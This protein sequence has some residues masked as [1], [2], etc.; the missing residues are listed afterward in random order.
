MTVIYP[1]YPLIALSEHLHEQPRPSSPISM[2]VGEADYAVGEVFPFLKGKVGLLRV[3]YTVAHAEG[4]G[5]RSAGAWTLSRVFE[6]SRGKLFFWD[7]F[8]IR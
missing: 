4:H 2:Q 8:T 1:G 7:G 6:I 3:S 5:L